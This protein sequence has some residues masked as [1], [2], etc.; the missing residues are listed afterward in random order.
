MSWQLHWQALSRRIS[1]L[2]DAVYVFMT[3]FQST[4]EEVGVSGRYE[5][6]NRVLIPQANAVFV[7]V[8]DLWE[9]YA[10]VIPSAAIEAVQLYSK[11]RQGAPTKGLEGLLGLATILAAMK[12]ELDYLLADQDAVTLAVVERAF[13]HLQRTI[14]VDEDQR[15]R[16]CSGFSAKEPECER[17]GATHLLWHGIWAFK[18]NASGERTDLVLGAS[19]GKPFTERARDS[20]SRLVLTEW[21]LVR[22]QSRLQA[23][24]KRAMIQL[25]RYSQG[26]LAGIELRSARYVIIVSGDRH[27]EMPPDKTIDGILYRL[28][29]IVTSPEPPSKS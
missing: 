17:L 20:G 3:L 25:Q 14:V 1:G 21:K 5:H 23:A 13:E 11:Q 6:I 15:Q 26:S 28:V 10:D 7:A 22:S 27:L 8:H 19:I 12:S 4:K 9:T 2:L 29:N 18:V 24:I 16:W